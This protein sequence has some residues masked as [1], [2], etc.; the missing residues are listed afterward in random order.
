MNCCGQSAAKPVM[1]KGVYQHKKGYKRPPFSKEWRGKLA[2]ASK[3]NKS[4]WKGMK[5]SYRAVHMYIDKLLGKP[6]LCAECGTT[7]A[8]RYEWANISGKYLRD[9]SDY[10]RMCKSCHVKFDRAREAWG[11][12]KEYTQNWDVQRS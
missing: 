10:I 5:A 6:R 1:P 12:T 11:K 3:G 4:H 9:E 8:A 7:K 2:E